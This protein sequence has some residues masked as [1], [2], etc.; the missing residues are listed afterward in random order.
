MSLV[1]IDSGLSDQLGTVGA[2]KKDISIPK[3]ELGKFIMGNREVLE[4]G[5]VELPSATNGS[6]SP[7]RHFLCALKFPAATR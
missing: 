7:G 3:K 5:V 6:L 1:S 4:F 2:V